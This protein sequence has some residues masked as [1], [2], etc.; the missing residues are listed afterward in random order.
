MNLKS[1]DALAPSVRRVPIPDV[2]W[3]PAVL[4]GNLDVGKIHRA[5]FDLYVNERPAKSVETGIYLFAVD[6][7][8]GR[9]FFYWTYEN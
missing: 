2:S 5:G 1:V 6:L 7:S 3:W 4:E 8:N 9:G